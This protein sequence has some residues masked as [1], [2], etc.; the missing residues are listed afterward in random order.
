[1]IL[2]CFIIHALCKQQISA[3]KAVPRIGISVA[4]QYVS[5]ERTNVSAYSGQ[6]MAPLQARPHP[7]TFLRRRRALLAFKEGQESFW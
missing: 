2:N 7:G 1:M 3:F 6:S 5:F 4:Q